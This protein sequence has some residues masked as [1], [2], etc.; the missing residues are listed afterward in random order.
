MEFSETMFSGTN[1]ISHITSVHYSFQLFR[2]DSSCNINFDLIKAKNVIET[3]FNRLK[4]FHLISGGVP[5]VHMDGF[6]KN[7]YHFISR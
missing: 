1:K 5:Q 7:I 4:G 6:L 2:I 3:D